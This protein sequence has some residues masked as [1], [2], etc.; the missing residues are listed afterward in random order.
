MS[1]VT[2]AS[3]YLGPAFFFSLI[4][5]FGRSPRDG[6]FIEL[7]GTYDPIPDR[8]KA[9]SVRLDIDRFKVRTS[10]SVLPRFGFSSLQDRCIGVCWE[11]FIAM[12]KPC[13]TLYFPYLLFNPLLSS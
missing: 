2:F 8:V 5:Y 3:P 7:L 6:R 9:K 4:L 10:T 1:R 12:C 11:Y 13:L